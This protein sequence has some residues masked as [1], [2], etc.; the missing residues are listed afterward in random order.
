MSG[1]MHRL[2]FLLPLALLLCACVTH[3]PS[4]VGEAHLAA[5]APPALTVR[6][7]DPDGLPRAYDEALHAAFSPEGTA[8]PGYAARIAEQRVAKGLEPRLA[9]YRGGAPCALDVAIENVILPDA[10]RYTPLS[11]M[12]SF[13]V[14]VRLTGPDGAVLAETTR[15]LTVLSDMQR[16][17]G[18]LSGSAWAR[19]GTTRDLR[20]DAILSL[21][22]ATARVVA[23]AVTGG[24]TQTGL[25]GRLV[26]YPDRL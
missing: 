12:K 3:G 19:P 14:A 10:T 9:S 4:P 6:L 8:P 18:R 25:S 13:G 16:R 11:G 21:S 20:A 5:C 24:R 7:T 1:A 17:G 23:E 22:D 26:A 2:P 15:P